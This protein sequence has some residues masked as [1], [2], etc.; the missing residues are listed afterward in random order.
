MTAGRAQCRRVAAAV[1]AL[2]STAAAGCGPGWAST[3]SPAAGTLVDDACPAAYGDRARCARLFVYENRSSRSG[4]VI[5][6]RIVVLRALRD[7]QPDPVFFL[8]GGP[9]QAATETMYF[10]A[11][12][13]R[14]AVERR[15]L[16]YVDQRGTGGSNSLTCD[17][18]GPPSRP[19]TYFDQ[20]L[21]PARVRA[22]RER[23][24]GQAD[25]AQYTTSRS[26]DDLDEVRAALG[27]DKI[28]LSGGS[29]GT[30]LAL[31]YLR[32]FEPRVRTIVLDG[33]VDPRTHMP[34]DFGQMAQRALD[35]LLDECAADARC[36]AA[37]PNIRS[38]ARDV[39]ARLSA[40][41]AK[42]PVTHP[43]SGRRADVRLTREHVAEAIRYMTYVSRDAARVPFALHEAFTG[44]YSPVADFLLRGRRSGTFDGLYLSI[45]CAED[46][47]FVSAEAEAHDAPS[48]LG[49]Y[50]IRA[51]GVLA[52]S[53][54]SGQR[55]GR[56]VTGS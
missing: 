27:Y 44:N 28:N 21:P 3:R 6:L 38:E 55:A 11:A 1:A 25:L 51:R 18:Y 56:A 41:P 26:V 32:R 2:L 49:A 17:F 13:G 19:E 23:L 48:Y 20:F 15:D 47:P 34:E 7:R 52:R 45:T 14:R 31:E 33:A 12:A 50:R 10:Q 37:F 53:F 30:R 8:A 46:V 5:P 35:A 22:C 42:V 36:R 43:E 4:R 9:G 40:S 54:Q 24:E 29:Y 39:F 16:V